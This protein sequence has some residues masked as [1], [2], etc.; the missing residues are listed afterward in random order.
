MQPANFR[1]HVCLCLSADD[2]PAKKPAAAQPEK[3]KKG[4][5]PPK[6]SGGSSASGG[7]LSGS[8][9]PLPKDVAIV[10]LVLVFAG[11]G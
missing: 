3:S 4:P 10:G 1:A 7:L 9:R 11:L 5:K 6:R 2:T 8:W